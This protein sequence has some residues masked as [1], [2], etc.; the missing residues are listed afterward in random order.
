MLI[1]T[2]DHETGMLNGPGSKAAGTFKP[3]TNKGRYVVPGVEWG[4][5]DHTNQ[6]IPLYAKG[7]IAEFLNTYVRTKD[8]VRGAYIDNTDL[9][10]MV[11]AAMK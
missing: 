1:V 8:P 4:S 2:A 7:G 11:F 6:L 10:K 3:I 9:A 5:G